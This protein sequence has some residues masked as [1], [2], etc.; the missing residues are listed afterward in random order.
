MQVSVE[1]NMIQMEHVK[2]I[3]YRIAENI[4]MLPCRQK[5]VIYLKF[6]EELRRD[7]IAEAMNIN[8][9]TVSN[10]LQMAL[11]RLRLEIVKSKLRVS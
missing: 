8:P 1:D 11:K 2:I 10:L 7:E 3:T 6:F 5:E 4:D 9:Q